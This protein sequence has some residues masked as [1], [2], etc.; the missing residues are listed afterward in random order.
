MLYSLQTPRVLVIE[1]SHRA[2]NVIKQRFDGNLS[3]EYA[4][5]LPEALE[6]HNHKSFDLV[7]WDSISVPPEFSNSAQIIKKFLRNHGRTKAI[8]LFN[9]KEQDIVN[10]QSIR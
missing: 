3:L 9:T 8:I 5:S 6:S 7:V 1:K 2:G 4:S 10:T